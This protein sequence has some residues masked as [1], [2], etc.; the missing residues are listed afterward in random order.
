MKNIKK[1][2]IFYPLSESRQIMKI[3]F[4]DSYVIHTFEFLTHPNFSIE[5]VRQ[6]F[7]DALIQAC[8]K[9]DNRD[10]F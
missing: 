4:N 3:S 8:R 9:E 2:E 7:E 6:V 1:Q 10:I 5:S